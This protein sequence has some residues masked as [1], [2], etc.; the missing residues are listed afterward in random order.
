[1]NG[2]FKCLCCCSF[3]GRQASVWPVLIAWQWVCMNL[4]TCVWI[5]IL[6]VWTLH[7]RNPDSCFLLCYEGMHR[8]FLS[9]ILCRGNHSPTIYHLLKNACSQILFPEFYWCLCVSGRKGILH[10]TLFFCGKMSKFM[11]AFKT[12]PRAIFYY[13]MWLIDSYLFALKY[14]KFLYNCSDILGEYYLL[15]MM[16]QQLYCL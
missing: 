6:Q 7:G 2:K 5:F 12:N 10:I 14:L 16:P 1:M 9:N 11:K 13:W 8:Q 15:Y 4:S 3:F